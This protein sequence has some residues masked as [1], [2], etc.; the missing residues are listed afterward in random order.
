VKPLAFNIIRHPVGSTT[1]VKVVK[2]LSRA[3][4]NVDFFTTINAR[5][6]A[7]SEKIMAQTVHKGGSV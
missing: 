5:R 4:R 2:R 7:A 6:F 1:H 3:L